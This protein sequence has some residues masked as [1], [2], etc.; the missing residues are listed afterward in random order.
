MHFFEQYIE[1]SEEKGHVYVGIYH[2]RNS[3]SVKFTVGIERSD[4]QEKRLFF[5]QA[6]LRYN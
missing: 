5:E 1:Y 2:A 4:N 3:E 6:Y